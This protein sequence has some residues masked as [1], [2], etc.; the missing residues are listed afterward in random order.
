MRHS[1]TGSGRPLQGTTASHLK[2]CAGLTNRL[3]QSAR[4]ELAKPL[5]WLVPEPR[6]IR[7]VPCGWPGF[8]PPRDPL[9][10]FATAQEETH[11]H[12]PS[13][14]DLL[15]AIWTVLAL[16]DPGGDPGD[17]DEVLSELFDDLHLDLQRV[18]ESWSDEESEAKEDWADYEELAIALP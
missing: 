11:L 7:L 14:S 6:V 15:F 16:P 17:D 9:A 8:L 3:N 1:R 2:A 12:D 18:Q 13:H 10:R 4:R 5:H